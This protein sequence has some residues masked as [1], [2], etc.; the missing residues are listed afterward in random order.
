MPSATSRPRSQATAVGGYIPP[1]LTPRLRSPFRRWRAWLWYFKEVAARTPG[2]GSLA[3]SPAFP[4]WRLL[5]L[6]TISTP[7][8]AWNAA[9]HRI[10]AMIAWEQLDGGTRAKVAAILRQHPD[11]ARWQARAR[12]PDHDLAAFL[13]SSTWP[14]DIRHDTRF[15]TRGV[16]APTPTLAGFPDMERRLD[17]H[18]LD[19][20]DPKP[21][22]GESRS[23]GSLDRQLA[24][25]V[26]IVG[27]AKAAVELRAY[28]IP[29]LIH[30]VGD[31]HQP[32][33]TVSRYGPDGESDRGGNNQVV[34]NTFFYAR[35]T[36]MSL[37]RYWDDLPGPPWLRGSRLEAAVSSLLSRH[38]SP[39]TAKVP[40]QWIEE[41]QSIA[42][43]QAYPPEIGDAVP[44]ISAEFHARALA[45]A[46]RRVTEAGYRLAEVLQRLLR[47]EIQSGDAVQH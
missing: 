25:L 20:D 43:T 30:L 40:E 3:R 34:V 21:A 9:G 15:Y 29:W 27:D 47:D 41:S 8:L 12:T 2:Q 23:S 17:W 11:F 36:S 1:I 33:H 28:A 31:A 45:I 44:T 37:H 19:H 16:D 6:L 22:T 4:R 42:R 38:A 26:S 46:E 35:P 7:A 18:Y 13:E 32:L 39:P 10:T 14:D 5:F 24:T